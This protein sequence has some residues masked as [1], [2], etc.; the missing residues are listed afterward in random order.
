M[1]G[2]AAKANILEVVPNGLLPFTLNIDA[3]IVNWSIARA[4]WGIAGPR[5]TDNDEEGYPTR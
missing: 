2:T 1:R 5:L 4:D 3:P